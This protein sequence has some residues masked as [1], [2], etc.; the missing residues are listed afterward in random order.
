MPTFLWR[1]S[2]TS[3]GTKGLLKEGGVK[4]RAAIQQ[5]IEDPLSERILWKEFRV[6]ETIVVDVETITSEAAAAYDKI[7]RRRRGSSSTPP[8]TARPAS[9]ALSPAKTTRP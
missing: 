8:P 9:F 4:R 7:V 6:G 2:Y 3:E 5:M 1:A